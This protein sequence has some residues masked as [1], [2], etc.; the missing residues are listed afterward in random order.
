MTLISTL[1]KSCCWA[2]AMPADAWPAWR[3][4]MS[5]SHCS[6]RLPCSS[7]RSVG[8]RILAHDQLLRFGRDLIQAPSSSPSSTRPPPAS[9]QR[10]ITLRSSWRTRSVSC[11]T[12]VLQRLVAGLE[13]LVLFVVRDRG[14]GDAADLGQLG[15]Q[16][17]RLLGEIARA[18]FDS[19]CARRASPDRF[20]A[21]SS[22]A[23]RATRRGGPQ[24]QAGR[25]RPA[26]RT[27]YCVGTQP[28]VPFGVR[29]CVN[30][31]ALIFAEHFER[32]AAR[33]AGVQDPVAV[34]RTAP[35]RYGELVGD[36]HR[37]SGCGD[38]EDGTSRPAA[39]PARIFASNSS[40]IS[41]ARRR[42]ATIARLARACGA[43]RCSEIPKSEKPRPCGRGFGGRPRLS[44]LR[45]ESKLLSPRSAR[46]KH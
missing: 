15:L 33:Q 37:G 41:Q 7:D 10:S 21:R 6:S 1:L 19:R 11:V 8:A 44:A 38:A 23:L 36:V 17:L 27:R 18:P 4:A 40:L 22:A 45:F 34:G 39:A 28:S 3:P 29:T 30:P 12:C 42:A 32:G 14:R 35:Q 13:L 5:G 26:G 9:N 20:R 16:F 43:A 31:A 24:P 46:P 25:A 2:D